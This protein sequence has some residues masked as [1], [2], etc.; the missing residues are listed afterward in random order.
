MN[1]SEHDQ[2]IL[3]NDQPT[4][5]MPPLVNDIDEAGA[6]DFL[7]AHHVPI[8]SP[9]IGIELIKVVKRLE[10]V[11]QVYPLPATVD[12]YR[13]ALHLVLQVAAEHQRAFCEKLEQAL[14]E[15]D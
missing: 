8:I 6:G 13:L 11:Q 5:A 14:A 10:T 1:S 4:R 7:A 9:D 2:A 3:V 12:V 15:C